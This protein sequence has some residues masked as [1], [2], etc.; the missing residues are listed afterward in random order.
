MNVVRAACY[1]QLINNCKNLVNVSLIL[2]HHHSSIDVT[3][4]TTNPKCNKS[5]DARNKQG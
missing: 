1:G 5:D 3:K 4:N 2:L